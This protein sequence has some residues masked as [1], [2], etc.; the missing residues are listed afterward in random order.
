VEKSMV[1]LS[2]ISEEI[3]YSLSEQGQAILEVSQNMSIAVTGV[4]LISGNVSSI[5]RAKS[6][7]Q[8]GCTQFSLAANI[9]RAESDDLGK[10]VSRFLKDL[11]DKK[12]DQAYH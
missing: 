5:G 7:T 10:E 8:E 2:E 9:L 3:E 1:K 12:E 6:K 4:G 11:T